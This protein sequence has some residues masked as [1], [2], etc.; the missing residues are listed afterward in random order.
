MSLLQLKRDENREVA[1]SQD[2]AEL[3]N[4]FWNAPFT[5]PSRL[6]QVFDAFRGSRMPALNVSEDEQGYHYELDLPGLEEKEIQIQLM[7]RQI[8][9]SGER[10]WKEEKKEKEFHR[11]ESQFG[12]FQR[13]FVVPDDARID[14]DSIRASY[15]KGILTINVPK[16]APTPTRRIEVKKK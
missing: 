1:P 2:W 13:S 14:G 6:P 5:R 7:G 4:S 11:V 9:V 3:W 8:L 12:S 15:D 10:T 16:V